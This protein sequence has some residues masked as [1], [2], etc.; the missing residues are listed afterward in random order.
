MINN[1]T[2]NHDFSS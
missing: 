1:P 2:M